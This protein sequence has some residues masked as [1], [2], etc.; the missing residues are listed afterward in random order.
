MFKE[1]I[2][3]TV[4]FLKANLAFGL[5]MIVG[6]AIGTT[7]TIMITMGYLGG[8]ESMMIWQQVMCGG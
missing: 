8:M 1:A 5:G 4:K 2:D 3:Y 7:V 6:S